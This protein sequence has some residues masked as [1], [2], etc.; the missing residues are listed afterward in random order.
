M[1]EPRA[2][3]ASFSLVVSSQLSL[4]HS[5]FH[6]IGSF[7]LYLLFPVMLFSFFLLILTQYFFPLLFRDWKGGRKERETLM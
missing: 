5:Y 4:L 7:T 2:S 3:D 6:P 1:L